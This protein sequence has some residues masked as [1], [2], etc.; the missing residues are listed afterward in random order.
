MPNLTTVSSLATTPFWPI[1]ASRNTVQRVPP[2]PNGA[3]ML[4]EPSITKYTSGVMRV[5]ATLAD[6]H[7]LGPSPGRGSAGPPALPEIRP[8][9]PGLTE[10]VVA[11]P[12]IRLGLSV[13]SF[14]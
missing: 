2:P 3:F 5:A 4:D 9:L 12:G 6:A 13:G 10:G 11:P 1:S 8:P 14:E 7:T